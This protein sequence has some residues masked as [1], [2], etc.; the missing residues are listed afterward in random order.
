MRNAEE[1]VWEKSVTISWICASTYFSQ[2]TSA[3][4]CVNP[5]TAWL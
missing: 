1:L 4:N 5:C 3:W 2:D